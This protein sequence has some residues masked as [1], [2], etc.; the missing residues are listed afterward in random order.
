MVGLPGL[1]DDPRFKTNPDRVAHND[2]LVALLQEKIV[3][4]PSSHW[5]AALEKLGIPAGPVQYYDEVY[6]DPQILAREMVVETR[7]PVT[8]PFK[9]MGVPVK[10]SATPGSIRRPAPRLG[11]HT[12]DVLNAKKAAE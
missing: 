5:L 1:K 12:G 4:E 10:L 7:H 2:A 6:T 11:E 3:K 9:T 8:G